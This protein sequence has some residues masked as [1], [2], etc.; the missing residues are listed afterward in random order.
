MEIG[1]AMDGV[2]A[3]FP[4]I[5]VGTWK[6]QSDRYGKR[7]TS[8]IKFQKPSSSSSMLEAPPSLN[9][10]KY[11]PTIS[12]SSE[13]PFCLFLTDF[14][15]VLISPIPWKGGL[16]HKRCGRFYP[17]C[18]S[19]FHHKKPFLSWKM[20]FQEIRALFR[21]WISAFVTRKRYMPI[22]SIRPIPNTTI[23]SFMTR[24]R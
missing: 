24:H 17:I 20:F 19:G 12:H 6:N 14:W 9:I 2:L 18:S 16:V 13:D 1:R 11:S 7:K 4:K 15:E 22:V 8:W 23:Y 5:R 10:K 21:L 3:G